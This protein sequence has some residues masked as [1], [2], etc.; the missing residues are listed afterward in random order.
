MEMV[1]SGKVARLRPNEI[2]VADGFFMFA[3]MR[4]TRGRG[5]YP[6]TAGKHGHG[7]VLPE[8]RG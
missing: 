2:L 6:A 5:F 8:E 7:Q 1:D 4:F 3:G